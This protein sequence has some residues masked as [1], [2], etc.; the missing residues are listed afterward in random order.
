MLPF[1]N[2]TIILGMPNHSGIYIVIKNNLEN[3][4][5][6]VNLVIITFEKFRYKNFTQR[7]YNF[8]RK[9][10]FRDF[11]YKQKLEKETNLN[12]LLNT[13]NNFSQSDY[14]LVIRPDLFQMEVIDAIKKKSN[15][16]AGYQWDGLERYPEIHSYIPKFNKFFVFDRKD[17]LYPNVFP[18]TNFS[19]ESITQV[20]YLQNDYNSAY[21]IG[22]YIL[23]R[24]SVV[25]TIIKKLNTVKINSKAIIFTGLIGI[26]QE[27]EHV[28]SLDLIPTDRV[29]MYNENLVNVMQSGILIDVHNPIHSGLSFR[30]FEGLKYNKKVIT[31][32]E[33]VKDY[34]FYCEQNILIWKNQNITE[35][36]DFIKTPYIPISENI[37]RKYS[38]ENWI[39][40]IL[41]LGNYTPISLP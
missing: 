7:F 31:T 16:L 9:L 6:K 10:L 3:L 19:L 2:K 22:T 38:F 20:D 30:I 18:T 14:A 41:E 34:D 1:E 17:L 32:N 12:N 13:V 24:M 5:F 8:Y 23:E 27:I 26:D 33:A 4:G 25:S 36:S 28:R 39:R 29:M 35:I 21:F 40:Y 37:K 11:N 15:Y